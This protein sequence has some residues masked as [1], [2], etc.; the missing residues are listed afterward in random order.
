MWVEE[1]ID[2][3]S[4]SIDDDGGKLGDGNLDDGRFDLFL[5]GYLPAPDLRPLRV[6]PRVPLGPRHH[7]EIER[8][9]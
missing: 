1:F 9:R 4:P 8:K 7:S 5:F 2:G 6:P 3:G